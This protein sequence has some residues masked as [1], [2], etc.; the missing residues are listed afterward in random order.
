MLCNFTS[1]YHTSATQLAGVFTAALLSL[2]SP[3]LGE[4]SAHGNCA[5]ESKPPLDTQQGTGPVCSNGAEIAMLKCLPPFA[6]LLL[7]K[8]LMKSEISH[9]FTFILQKDCLFL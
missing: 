2:H 7:L 6:V 4:H 8:T 3:A 9:V 5:G 1:Q